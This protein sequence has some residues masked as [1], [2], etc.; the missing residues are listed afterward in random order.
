MK[1]QNWL[2][3]LV[4]VTALSF[5]A[6]GLAAQAAGGVETRIDEMEKRLER[7]ERSDSEQKVVIEGIRGHV[8]TLEGELG[9]VDY[10]TARIRAI[11][12]RVDAFSIGGD[13]TLVLQGAL[14]NRQ[15][16]GN[17]AEGSYNANLFITAPAGR[18]GNIFFRVNAGQG[19][20]LA[21]FL[22]ES[23]SGPNATIQITEP[24]FNLFEAWF[25]TSFAIPRTEPDRL[26]LTIGKLDP[27]GFFDENA[28]AN[29]ETGQFLADVFVNNL[30]LEFGGDESGFG[31]GAV[32][33]YR[34]T[35]A[36]N[37]GLNV[38]GKVGVFEADGDF[39]GM[40]NR[41]FAIAELG[42]ERPYY[43]LMG[44]YRV[45][46][47]VNEERHVDLAD[48]SRD[49]LSNKG[50]GVSLDQQVTNDVT[51]FARIG[52]QD[53][54]VSQFDRSFSLGLQAV[55]NPWKRSKDVLGIAYGNTRPSDKFKEL[56]PDVNFGDEHY[57]EA[58]YN[59]WVSE[60][61]TVSPDIQYVVN[62][63]GDRGKDDVFIYGVRGHFAF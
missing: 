38:T 4:T 21:G 30:A 33:T 22:P 3:L 49:N 48:P 40:F 20:G 13:L 14:K 9:M 2:S 16:G 36:Y 12:E 32:L 42:V 53:E 37:K 50:I 59:F 62:P 24:V 41:P 31:P 11:Q 5:P 44:N 54:D 7:L 39:E 34:F 23:F 52:I 28:V 43:G 60:N 29:S 46:A 10:R 15:A 6:H 26:G 58:Y 25:S 55:G 1:A 8:D 47:W 61:V 17:R 27:A 56:S 45:Y 63:G 35:S 51:L 18:N 19:E 57:M